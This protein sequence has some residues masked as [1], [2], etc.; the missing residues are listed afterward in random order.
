M[1]STTKKSEKSR[2]AHFPG[3]SESFSLLALLRQGF[4]LNSWLMIMGLLMIIT[5]L[6]TGVGLIVDQRVITGAPAWVK[7][8]KFALSFSIYCF[9]F[10]WLLKFVQRWRFFTS[11]MGALASLGVLGEMVLIV[12]Q[13]I[14][15]VGSHFNV[16]TP[17]DKAIYNTMGTFAVMIW[18]AAFVVAILLL[19][20]RRTDR[21][22]IWSL[23]LGLMIALFGMYVGVIMT[24]PTT[25]Q[26]VAR[27]AGHMLTSGAHSVGVLDGG[28]G[29]PFL[30]W[31]TVGGDLRIAHFVG[32]HALQVLPFIGWLLSAQRFPH[33][34]TG[35]RV[36][37]VWVICLGYLGLTGSLLWQAL[38][39]QSLIAPDALTWLSW[40]SV[41]GFTLIACIAIVLSA[42]SNAARDIQPIA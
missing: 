1:L 11:I 36:A 23:R 2:L 21:A 35:R 4:V 17:F 27:H 24:Q 8:A 28:S 13:V 41:I 33:L 18:V 37:L 10:V 20:E 7:P 3:S 34:G 15:G 38:R 40:S 26:L 32:L 25:A 42:R 30:G 16:A 31:S 19:F 12:L 14:R 9:T 29:L 39:G 5:L 22:L 6:A